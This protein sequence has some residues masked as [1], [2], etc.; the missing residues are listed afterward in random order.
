MCE[1]NTDLK[2]CILCHGCRSR[3]QGCELPLEVFINLHLPSMHR[4]QQP[5]DVIIQLMLHQ[6]CC[7]YLRPCPLAQAL[8]CISTSRH[9][10]G[11]LIKRA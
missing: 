10:C 3:H 11:I 1:D 5:D 7:A 6:A 9:E 4:L 2:G 8:V